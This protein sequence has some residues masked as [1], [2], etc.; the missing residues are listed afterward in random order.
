MASKTL[1]ESSEA[2]AIRI[3]SE[4]CLMDIFSQQPIVDGLCF[5]MDITPS[6]LQEVTGRIADSFDKQ[7]AQITS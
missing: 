3:V 7:I 6:E 1:W 4:L 2:Q 5:A